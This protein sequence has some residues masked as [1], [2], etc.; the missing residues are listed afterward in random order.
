[1]RLMC[2]AVV[3]TAMAG[4]AFAQEQASPEELG[5]KYADALE[6]LKASQDRKNELAAEND[7]L[8][9]R[10]AE[11]EQQS[12][13]HRRAAA[14]FAEQTF[15]LRSHYAAW[16][17]FVQRYP[18]LAIQWKVFLEGGLLAGHPMPSWTEPAGPLS[19]RSSWPSSFE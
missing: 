1:M 3:L 4:A 18:Q 19:S 8:R 5:R 7:Q 11:L 17:N 14:E 9:A 16:Q 6:Q 12:A 10:I 2:A 15:F 13:E